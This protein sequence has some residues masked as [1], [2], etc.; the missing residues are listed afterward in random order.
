MNDRAGHASHSEIGVLAQQ[1][2]LRSAQVNVEIYTMM[3]M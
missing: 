1:G 2:R 3:K